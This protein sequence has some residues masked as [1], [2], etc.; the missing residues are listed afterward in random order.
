MK[1]EVLND[2]TKARCNYHFSL[3]D[4]GRKHGFTRERARQL[5]NSHFRVPYSETQKELKNELDKVVR[6]ARAKCSFRTA[7]FRGGYRLYAIAECK[8]LKKCEDLSLNAK[9][10]ETQLRFFTVNGCRVRVRCSNE[11]QLQCKAAKTKMH[12][13]RRTESERGLIDFYA[14]YVYPRDSFFIVPVDNV[15]ATFYVPERETDYRS[16]KNNHL[17]YREAWHLLI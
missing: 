5:F 9:F 4:V 13:F 7:F 10:S 12:L 11:S 3:A 17:K 1:T 16:S 6:N 8:F 15:R 2:L 14:F